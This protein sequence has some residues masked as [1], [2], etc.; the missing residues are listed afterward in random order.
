MCHWFAPL[1]SAAGV[2]PPSESQAQSP[3]Y[4]ADRV[5]IQPKPG[6]CP[7][8]LAEFHSALKSEVLQTFDA[9]GGLQVLRVPDGET[10]QTLITKYEQSGQVEFAEPDYT[11]RVFATPNDPKFLDGT[12][13]ALN[14][15]GQN[16]GTPGADIDAPEAW[17][18]L[19]SASNIVV[20]VLDTGVRYTH[21]DLGSNMWVNAR[22]GSHGT[23]AL[24]GTTDPS[25]DSGHGTMI[26][27][28]LGAVGNNCKGVTGGRLNLWKALRPAIRLA[29]LSTTMNGPFR[30]RV[31]SEPGRTC[32]IEVATALECWSPVFTNSTSVDGAFDFT[33]AASADSA[34]R[35]YRAVSF[36]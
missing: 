1:I 12:L 23:N 24:A 3:V 6:T 36:P 21:E 22:D 9:I 33:D 31:S 17:D 20:A 29:P 5:L 16:G 14:N 10:V 34:R 28:I 4:R 8:A 26:A 7:A 19:T 11:G 32:V 25:D 27:G 18:V 15:T 35:F 13:W 2:S 30:L